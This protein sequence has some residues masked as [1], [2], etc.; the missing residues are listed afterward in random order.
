MKTLFFLL[1]YSLFVIQGF[2]QFNNDL[3]I[4]EP[5]FQEFWEY[6]EGG[7]CRDLE[8]TIYPISQLRE[9]HFNAKATNYGVLTQTNVVLQVEIAGPGY[10][11][12]LT[13]IPV[14]ISSG[15]FFVFEID[16]WM[17]PSSNGA[18]VVSFTIIS[19]VED[20][21]P[22]NNSAQRTFAISSGGIFMYPNPASTYA[23]DSGSMEGSFTNFTN[24][25]KIGNAFYMENPATIWAIGVALAQGSV[26]GIAF[27]LELLS[28]PD[29]DYMGETE[30]MTVPPSNQLNEI[31]GSNFI[32]A[33][34]ESYTGVSLNA[35]SNYVVV[36]NHFG[37]PNDIVV[38]TSGYS[39]DSSSFYYDG[40]NTTWLSI[41]ETPMV[42]MGTSL[43]VSVQE[44]SVY[45][46][47]SIFPNPS[48]SIIYLSY[49]GKSAPVRIEFYDVSGR[50]MR[51]DE[52]S[53]INT[54]SQIT[55][56]ISDM[57]SGVIMMKMQTSDKIEVHK[58]IKH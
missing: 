3:G 17:P 54:N 18:Y 22:E 57:Q 38:A 52:L 12:T 48:S 26:P 49:S 41:N 58:L 43:P 15:E 11:E 37:G 28:F 30:L 47:F 53:I 8:Y 31:G 42:R 46:E 36:V 56:D 7:D 4:S 1:F 27:N 14:S 45:N 23:R 44:F 32:W 29:L 5:R 40:N 16:S 13:S 25:Y 20:D 19:E 50:L 51:S 10:S 35:G 33:E 39:P 55:L 34:M 2:A 6:E 21:F 24:D 9:L